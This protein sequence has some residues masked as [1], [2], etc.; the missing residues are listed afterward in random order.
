MRASYCGLCSLDLPVAFQGEQRGKGRCRYKN[1]LNKVSADSRLPEQSRMGAVPSLSLELGQ[2]VERCSSTLFRS[3]KNHRLSKYSRWALSLSTC[4][5]TLAQGLR[6]A[7]LSAELRMVLSLGCCVPPFPPN[8]L[9]L[10]T[11]QSLWEAV[12]VMGGFRNRAVH[13]SMKMNK[14][15]VFHTNWSASA[16]GE[17][18]GENRSPQVASVCSV[19][20][21]NSLLTALVTWGYGAGMG[22]GWLCGCSIYLPGLS[23]FSG[24]A[25]HKGRL[26]RAVTHC[27][28]TGQRLWR[29]QRSLLWVVISHSDLG[30]SF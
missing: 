1:L 15:V 20:Q 25:Y 10:Y 27:A 11:V 8:P 13:P 6:T 2:D 17:V 14:F 3:F 30:E 4:H 21:I 24:C 12:R 19:C 26:G 9:L 7:L 29:G 22:H 23:S 28:K 16:T 5:P 18:A